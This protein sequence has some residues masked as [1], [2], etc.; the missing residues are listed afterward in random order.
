MVSI[1]LSHTSHLEQCVCVWGEGGAKRKQNNKK[2]SLNLNTDLSELLVKGNAARSCI[3]WN[4][5]RH[6]LPLG[7]GNVTA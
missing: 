3:Q 1:Y 2:G 7:L 5:L 6:A 4:K